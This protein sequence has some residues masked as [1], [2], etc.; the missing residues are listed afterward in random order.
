MTPNQH[1]WLLRAFP[2]SVPHFDTFLKKSVIGL[3]WPKIGP[4]KKA[5][6]AKELKQLFIENDYPAADNA[7]L[8][9]RAG[10]FTRFVTDMQIGDIVMVPDNKGSV[11]VYKIRSDYYYDTTITPYVTH[12]RRVKLITF[13]KFHSL[14]KT[15]QRLLSN[16]LSLINLDKAKE[17]IMS[18][19]D[20]SSHQEQTIINRKS[21]SVITGEIKDKFVQVVIPDNISNGEVITILKD[22][23][24]KLEK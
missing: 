11:A 8:G 14:S 4:L 20:D 15:L 5:I 24:N 3:G 21:Q 6:T 12:L 19:I 16:Q 23:I 7:A 17:E 1:F 9:R 13:L 2:D 10:F 22:I 18:L